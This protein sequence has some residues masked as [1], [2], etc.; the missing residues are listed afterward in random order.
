MSAFTCRL[1]AWAASCFWVDF[2]ADDLGC[3]AALETTA[4]QAT[5]G[6]NHLPAMAISGC[7]F[8]VFPQVLLMV[9]GGVAKV[10]SLSSPHASLRACGVTLAARATRTLEDSLAGL[11]ARSEAEVGLDR[12]LLRRVRPGVFEVVGAVV[13]G[14]PAHDAAGDVRG[15]AA[16]HG[17]QRLAQAQAQ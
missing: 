17:R 11:E 13:V 6:T 1:R 3:A 9:I 15:L 14:G 16:V 12:D 7:A 5:M 4:A 10:K 2:G 8:L